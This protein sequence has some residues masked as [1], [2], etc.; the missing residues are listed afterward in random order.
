MYCHPLRGS[1]THVAAQRCGAA[2]ECRNVSVE[3]ADLYR[4]GFDPTLREPELRRKISFD[5]LI[6]SYDRMV[7]NSALLVFVH[8]DWWG[9]PPA[10]LKGWLDRVLRPGIAYEY[11]GGEFETKRHVG[12]LTDKRALVIVTTNRS[13]DQPSSL[14]MV[15][16]EVFHFCGVPYY[17]I[18][19][20]Y[21]VYTSTR[22]A[23]RAWL[24]QIEQRVG[25]L[26]VNAT[27]S[28]GAK[29]ENKI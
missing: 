11:Q 8:P 29:K 2:L 4:Q 1:L 19:I 9:Q 7:Y 15:W 5:P 3:Y 24:D 6:Q 10:M 27:Q 14:E 28:P 26:V 18:H 16:R 23:R 12:L 20:L 22:Q 17:T 25:T 13:A 21:D